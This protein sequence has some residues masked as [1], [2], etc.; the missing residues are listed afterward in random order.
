MSPNL[1]L[2][3]LVVSRWSLA[4]SPRPQTTIRDDSFNWHVQPICQRPIRFPPERRAF[5]PE[6]ITHGCGPVCPR[7]LLKLQLS[8]YSCQPE[9]ITRLPQLLHSCEDSKPRGAQCASLR[10]TKGVFRRDVNQ[11]RHEPRRKRA[12]LKKDHLEVLASGRLNP[13]R[14]LVPE[15][16]PV[17]GAIFQVFSLFPIRCRTSG[18]RFE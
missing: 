1:S 15:C 10:A 14:S 8:S 12:N 7:N 2:P 13:S 11:F 3:S 18:E 4:R 16:S 6:Q 5:S 9:G 17:A